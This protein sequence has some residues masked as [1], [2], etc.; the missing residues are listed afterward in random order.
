MKDNVRPKKQITPT[1][2]LAQG[3]RLFNGGRISC[4]A[5]SNPNPASV[6]AKVFSSDKI[7]VYLIDKQ[8]RISLPSSNSDSSG[9][10]QHFQTAVGAVTSS[11]FQHL[12]VY[13]G[14]AVSRHQS[15]ASQQDD[16]GAFA[17]P[18]KLRNVV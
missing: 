9:S 2:L 10:F 5:L 3:L 17:T 14:D 4:T 13:F 12:L 16:S 8:L 6:C 1:R 7:K 11:G 18:S 15:V